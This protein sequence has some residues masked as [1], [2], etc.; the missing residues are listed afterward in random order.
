[1]GVAKPA[2]HTHRQEEGRGWYA[3][4]D[5]GNGFDEACVP[6]ARGGYARARSPQQVTDRRYIVQSQ[7]ECRFDFDHVIR[8]NPLLAVS[9]VRLLWVESGHRLGDRH[10]NGS[11]G[12]FAV[13][14]NA[15]AARLA[16]QPVVAPPAFS[17]P[18]P[19]RSR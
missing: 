19:R 6:V 1:M 16:A 7:W 3:H 9:R 13:D 12:L 10:G 11:A 8:F 14:G 15:A 17:L 18:R 5:G 4:H 2:A